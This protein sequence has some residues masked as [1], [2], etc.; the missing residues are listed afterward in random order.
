MAQL[1]VR[2]LEDGVKERLRA[3]A[4]RNKRSL[5]AEAREI[6]TQAA[7]KEHGERSAA[8]GFGTRASARFKGIGFSRKELEIFNRAVDEARKQRP[9]FVKFVP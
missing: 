3:R 2:N 7:E 8:T 4:K 6:L 1:I 5:E 9:R